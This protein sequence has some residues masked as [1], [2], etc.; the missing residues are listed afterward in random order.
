MGQHP[1]EPILEMSSI[2][3]SLYI[4]GHRTPVTVTVLV[5]TD[6]LVHLLD[7]GPELYAAQV[8]DLNAAQVP[9]ENRDMVWAA[10]HIGSMER[11]PVITVESLEKEGSRIFEQLH[12]TCFAN[13][14]TL[15]VQGDLLPRNHLPDKLDLSKHEKDR[16]VIHLVAIRFRKA[17]N[18]NDFSRIFLGYH[19]PRGRLPRMLSSSCTVPL[20]LDGTLVEA[21]RTPG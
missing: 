6:L 19:L 12:E 21:S 1:S 2:N 16:M 3:K 7:P 13:G 4:G 14:Q 11:S 10:A 9:T 20:D 8:P 5:Q 17:A 15:M 18:S